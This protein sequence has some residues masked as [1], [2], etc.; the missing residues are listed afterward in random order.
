MN[1]QQ[2]GLS[3]EQW[4]AACQFHDLTP[5]Q[6]FQQ[7]FAQGARVQN[8]LALLDL[9]S[10][11]FNVG[12]RTHAIL[13][14]GCK[15][16]R[17]VTEFKEIA[18][19]FLTLLARSPAETFNFYSIQ[20]FLAHFPLF[21]GGSE[22]VALQDFVQQ[23]RAYWRQHFF[24]SAA[25]SH[26]LPYAGAV[27]FV[28]QLHQ[29]QFRIIYL[30]G[31]DEP[32]MGEGTRLSLATH[33]FPGEQEGSLLWMKEHRQLD[34]LAYKVRASQQLRALGTLVA[35]FENEPVNCSSLCEL[36]PEAMHVFVGTVFSDQPAAPR[37]GLYKIKDFAACLRF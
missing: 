4:I 26:D 34:D 16:F 8:P 36:F 6:V 24:S 20:D 15:Q 13:Q 31:R 23:L 33:G 10:T 5:D 35:S 29:A 28:R 18:D 21:S 2:E 9:D 3:R 12:P 19:L 37:Q 32:M 11:L 7:V 30:T 27:S 14:Q 22:A 25:L 1:R 17:Q